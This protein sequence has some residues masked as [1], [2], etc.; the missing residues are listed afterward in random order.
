MELREYAL[1]ALETAKKDLL[2][3]RYLLPVVFIVT[4]KEIL[5]F[6]IE[7]Q[8]P[9]QKSS[10][11]SEVV[12]IAKEKKALA[13]I[14]V[15]DATIKGPATPG[16]EGH[17][18]DLSDA[19]GVQECIFVTISGPGIVTWSVSLPYL[20]TSD[21]IV[22]GSPQET[23]NDILNLLPGWPMTKPPSV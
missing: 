20:R 9:K 18:P 16:A 4:E 11:Y 21:D 23:V 3:D 8:G 13:I 2:R 19:K 17:R 10:A 15:N 22:F 12:E 6:N 5:D 7:F 1:R 14:T